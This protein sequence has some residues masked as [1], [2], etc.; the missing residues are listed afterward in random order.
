[1]N[2]RI[3]LLPH[4]EERRKTQ[5]CTDRVTEIAK[6]DA[7]DRCQPGAPPLNEAAGHDVEHRGTRRHQQHQRRD[8]EQAEA[9]PLR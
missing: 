2:A 4:R 5:R 8:H 9:R 7:H 1:M 6:R 3:N